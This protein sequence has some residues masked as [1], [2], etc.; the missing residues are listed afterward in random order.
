MLFVD[1]REVVL[2]F[3]QEVVLK[4]LHVIARADLERLAHSYTLG[5][6]APFSFSKNVGKNGSFFRR[7]RIG[8]SDILQRPCMSVGP[9]LDKAL[10]QIYN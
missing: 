2:L 1:V 5:M 4:T 3:D 7:L 6:E 10:F 9:S 8:R